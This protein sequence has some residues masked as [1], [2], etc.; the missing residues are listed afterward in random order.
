MAQRISR[1]PARLPVEQCGCIRPR[2]DINESQTCGLGLEVGGG[3]LEG[4]PASQRR[5]CGNSLQANGE[6][7]CANGRPLTGREGKTGAARWSV[8]ERERPS[9]NARPAGEGAR[10]VV[11]TVRRQDRVFDFLGEGVWMVTQWRTI[12]SSV[13]FWKDNVII[14]RQ[15]S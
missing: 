5:S 10:L 15:S 4:R 1:L 3:G 9:L 2:L 13:C 14:G 7:R 8:G 6:G 11:R 12:Q